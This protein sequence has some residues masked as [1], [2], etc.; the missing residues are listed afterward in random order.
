MLVPVKEIYLRQ[1]K[2][3]QWKRLQELETVV[4]RERESNELECVAVVDGG[5]TPTEL[6]IAIGNEDK[7]QFF[8]ASEES[9]IHKDQDSDLGVYYSE[10]KLLYSS[11][12]PL[13]EFNDLTITCT[14]V[15]DG[16]QNASTSALLRVECLCLLIIICIFSYVLFWC[17]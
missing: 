7:T 14:A 5:L 3:Y 11:M 6:S 10:F 13:R 16:F 2:F 4:L 15:Q 12:N 1:K 17:M 9:K 8:T